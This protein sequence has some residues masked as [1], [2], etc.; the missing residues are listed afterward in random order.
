M[1][2]G[3]DGLKNPWKQGPKFWK[4]SVEKHTHNSGVVL[5]CT[6]NSVNQSSEILIDH[7]IDQKYTRNILVFYMQ[8]ACKL[9]QD[10]NPSDLS[11][12]FA[13]LDCNFENELILV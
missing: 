8:N 13:T 6:Q 11:I 5:N 4:S 3:R 10:E 2:S 12:I 1:L 7:M 9:T